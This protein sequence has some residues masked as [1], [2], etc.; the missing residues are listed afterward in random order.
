MAAEKERLELQL[1]ELR[2]KHAELH[3]LA[4][5]FMHERDAALAELTAIRNNTGSPSEAGT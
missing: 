1:Y 4:G 3:E 2:D 5:R